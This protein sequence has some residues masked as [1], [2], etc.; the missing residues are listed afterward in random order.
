MNTTKHRALA[1]DPLGALQSHALVDFMRADRRR[2]LSLIDDL[3]MN[4][5]IGPKIPTVN[6]PLWE[7]GHVAWFAEFWL[8]RHLKGQRPLLSNG[9]ELYNSTDVAHDARWDLLLPTRE[10]TL[11]FMATILERCIETVDLPRALTMPMI[12]PSDNAPRFASAETE[13]LGTL[14]TKSTSSPTA[15]R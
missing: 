14:T 7:I 4:Q 15:A 11:D 3:D 2:T 12:E 1:P 5:L 13:W 8:L 10:K 6:P 9:D